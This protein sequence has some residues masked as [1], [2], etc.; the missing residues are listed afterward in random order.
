MKSTAGSEIA[1]SEAPSGFDDDGRSSVGG[2]SYIHASQIGGDGEDRPQKPRRTKIQLWDDL[3][4]CGTKN[5]VPLGRYATNHLQPS[6]ER[7]P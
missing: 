6:H 2:S 5:Q 3:K 4:I 7:L 1:P